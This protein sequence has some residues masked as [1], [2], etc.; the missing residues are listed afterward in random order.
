MV[1]QYSFQKI[2]EMKKQEKEKREQEYQ[3]SVTQFELAAKSLYKLLSQKE[4]IETLFSGRMASGLKIQELQQNESML[5]HLHDRIATATKQTDTARS[6]MQQKE[7]ELQVAA[8]EWKK[9]EKMKERE[10]EKFA[11]QLKKD[12]AAMM[13]EISIRNFVFSENR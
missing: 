13:D 1:F 8:I 5:F 9:Y 10:Q 11:E 6:R 12:E 3:H 2:L 7:T 4:Q